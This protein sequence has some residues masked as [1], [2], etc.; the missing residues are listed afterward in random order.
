MT[1]SHA[2]SHLE[3]GFV[4]TGDEDGVVMVGFALDGR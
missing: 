4:H 2:S 3:P 1:R